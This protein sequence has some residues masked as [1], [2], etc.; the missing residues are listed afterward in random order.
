MQ[1]NRCTHTL[2][3]DLGGAVLS[4][5]ASLSNFGTSIGA[6]RGALPQ[7]A[8]TIAEDAV[9]TPRT[10]SAASNELLLR[11]LGI[12]AA[13]CAA[14]PSGGSPLSRATSLCR[15][16]STPLSPRAAAAAGAAAGIPDLSCESWF[17]GDSPTRSAGSLVGADS[18]MASFMALSASHERF[19]QC[20][21]L[22]ELLGKGGFGRVRV[23]GASGGGYVGGG[24]WRQR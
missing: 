24:S 9:L 23:V 16:S 11:S 3:Q 6:F 13:L 10:A 21:K 8:D 20:T 7:G 18:P 22:G 12:T 2:L 5:D 15:A 1:P 4:P 19:F 17:V 14:R